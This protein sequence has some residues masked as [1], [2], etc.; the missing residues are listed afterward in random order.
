[1]PKRDPEIAEYDRRFRREEEMEDIGKFVR[2]YPHA[3]GE[4]LEIEESSDSPDAICRRLGGTLVGVEH[5][6]V[7]RSPE[8]A[9][10]GSILHYREE[11]DIEDTIDEIN[12]LIF[13][14]AELVKNFKIQPRRAT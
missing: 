11:M 8:D 10:W 2:A 14:K 6:R 4:M 1:M 3:T 9:R 5:T 13:R 7:R 12:R